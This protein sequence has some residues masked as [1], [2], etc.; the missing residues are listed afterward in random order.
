MKHSFCAPLSRH[1]VP[2][3]TIQ[4]LPL[5]I[6]RPSFLSFLVVT[7]LI[8]IFIIQGLSSDFKIRERVPSDYDIFSLKQKTYLSGTEVFLCAIL[9]EVF[10]GYLSISGN[11]LAIYQISIISEYLNCLKFCGIHVSQSIELIQM[12]PVGVRI[13]LFARFVP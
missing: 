5:G 11:C 7:I 9:M 13:P 2:L 6:L 12:M 10:K 8:A 1:C 4:S 3:R